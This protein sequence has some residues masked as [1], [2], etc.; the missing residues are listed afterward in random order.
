[1][2]KVCLNRLLGGVLPTQHATVTVKWPQKGE[3]H[4][5]VGMLAQMAD[6]VRKEKGFSAPLHVREGHG[7]G[8]PGASEEHEGG[9]A[10]VRPLPKPGST[11]GWTRRGRRAS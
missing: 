6:A 7:Q 10:P 2:H 1:M 3:E 5:S 4:A 8:E 9:E 11:G